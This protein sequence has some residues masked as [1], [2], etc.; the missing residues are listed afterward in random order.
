MEHER[1]LGNEEKIIEMEQRRDHWIQESEL[2]VKSG[3]HER[4]ETS[5]QNP[6]GYPVN[7]RH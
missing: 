1:Y 2:H 4:N 7:C 3:D 5:R 6:G